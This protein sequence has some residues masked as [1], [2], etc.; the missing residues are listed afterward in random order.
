VYRFHN[1]F[2][3]LEL[4][5]SLTKATNIADANAIEPE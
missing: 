2:L 4:I 5:R 3:S 1:L